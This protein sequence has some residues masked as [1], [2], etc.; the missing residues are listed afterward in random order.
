MAKK[1]LDELLDDCC[2]LEQPLKKKFVNPKIKESNYYK[3]IGTFDN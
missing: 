1:N 3:N 2:P